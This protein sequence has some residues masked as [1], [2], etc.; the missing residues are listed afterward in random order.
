MNS[1]SL[2][3]HKNSLFVSSKSFSLKQ[4]C[5]CNCDFLRDIRYL[6]YLPN[7]RPPKLVG[8]TSFSMGATASTVR[9]VFSRGFATFWK[10]AG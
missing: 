4:N 5:K 3:Y 8:S 2:F 6:V 1:F 7:P 10:S 9:G